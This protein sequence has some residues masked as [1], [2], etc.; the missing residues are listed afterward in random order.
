M[1]ADP[2]PRSPTR[3]AL[4]LQATTF[5]GY[6]AP[7]LSPSFKLDEGYSDDTRSQSDKEPIPENV[8]MLPGWML[9]LGETDRAGKIFF[10]RYT[11]RGHSQRRSPL[12]APSSLPSPPADS[13]TPSTTRTCIQPSTIIINLNTRRCGRPSQSTA[14]YGPRCQA[15]PRT[16]VR[17]LFLP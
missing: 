11:F 8:M 5:P 12:R 16:D 17:D 4:Q 1:D 7:S 3:P 9:S 6:S 13:Y 10:H 14:P 2:H 15:P